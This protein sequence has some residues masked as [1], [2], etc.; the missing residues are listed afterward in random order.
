[1]KVEVCAN[2]LQ[3]AIRAEKAGADRIE[4]CSELGVGGITPSFGLLKKVREKLKIPIHVLIRPRSGDFCYNRAE[5]EIMKEDILYCRSTGVNGIVT[6]AL[7]ADGNLDLEMISELKRVCGPLNF[8]FHR[9]FDWVTS[10]LEALSQ[11]EKIGVDILLTSGMEQSAL[12]GWDNLNQLNQHANSITV[13]PGGGIGI[14]A[15][16]KFKKAGFD[17]IHLSGSKRTKTMVKKPR[18]S[19]FSAGM[20]TDDYVTETDFEKVQKVVNS[21]K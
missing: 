12:K 7:K 1:M 8:T 21:V 15:A 11:L 5:F 6:G 3:S 14:T 10:P 4:L 16:K 9:A 18:V 13:M 19:M 20:L 17:A 2:S